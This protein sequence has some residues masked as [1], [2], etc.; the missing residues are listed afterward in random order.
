MS[1]RDLPRRTRLSIYGGVIFFL[2]VWWAAF[3]RFLFQDYQTHIA[4]LL[5]G[6]ASIAIFLPMFYLCYKVGER[7]RKIQKEV[8]EYFENKYSEN[9]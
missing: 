9:K 5:S 7:R 6:V 3:Y 1:I 2:L 8:D 4:I